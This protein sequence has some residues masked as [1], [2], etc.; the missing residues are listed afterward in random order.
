MEDF[1][2]R[3]KKRMHIFHSTEDEELLE[4]LET[5]KEDI[6]SLC[7][8][9]DPSKN[10]KGLELIIERS[11]YVYNDSLEFFYDNFQEPILNLSV[12]LAGRESGEE[13]GD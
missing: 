4:S 7:G 1:L 8:T 6:I 3:F 2:E 13:D 12:D 5:S 9:F 11:R 10:R